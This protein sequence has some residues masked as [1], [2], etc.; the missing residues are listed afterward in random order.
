MP[1]SAGL[2]E[3]E[4]KLSVETIDRHRAF[5]SIQENLEGSVGGRGSLGIGS[6]KAVAP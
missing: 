5:V 4:A 2:H 3:P 1:K 6:L